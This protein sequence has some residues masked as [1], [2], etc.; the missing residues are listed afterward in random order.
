M[1]GEPDAR[2]PDGSG[3][4]Q[5]LIHPEN[6]LAATTTRSK[7]VAVPLIATSREGSK[8]LELRLFE[9]RNTQIMMENKKNGKQCHFFYFLNQ[10]GQIFLY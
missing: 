10:Q 6:C 5:D 7:T 8:R 9:Q 4:H 1:V 2:G 3:G